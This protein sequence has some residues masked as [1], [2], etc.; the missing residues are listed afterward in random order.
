[1]MSNRVKVEFEN[2]LANDDY[3][4]I[5]SKDGIIKGIWIPDGEDQDVIPESIA[6]LCI[7][8]FHFDPNDKDVSISV[9]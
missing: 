1:M 8:Y 4:L 6:N 3:G 7:K 9:H 2:A 5:I